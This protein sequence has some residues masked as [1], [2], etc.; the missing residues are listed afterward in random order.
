M[1]LIAVGLGILWLCIFITSCCK[2]RQPFIYVLC[3]LFIAYSMV[4]S[5]DYCYL[6]SLLK[7]IFYEAHWLLA[8]RYFQVSENMS[9]IQSTS[10][11]NDCAI[12]TF[13]ILVSL[14][15]VTTFFGFE[16]LARARHITKNTEIYFFPEPFI[17]LDIAVMLTGLIRVRSILREKRMKFEIQKYMVLHMFVLLILLFGKFFLFKLTADMLSIC[18]L[19]IIA[20]KMAC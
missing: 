5:L 13:N 9:R 17:I 12:W 20:L 16:Y 15:I 18:S 6:D 1:Q 8:W 11:C 7:S 19:A 14:T 3:A 2:S 10:Y 4:F